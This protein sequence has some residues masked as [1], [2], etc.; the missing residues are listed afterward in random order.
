MTMLVNLFFRRKGQTPLCKK[1]ET[2]KNRFI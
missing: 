2:I 1:E